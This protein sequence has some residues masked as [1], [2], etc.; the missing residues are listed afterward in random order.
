MHNTDCGYVGLRF[1]GGGAALPARLFQLASFHSTSALTVTNQFTNARPQD[2][3][4][5]DLN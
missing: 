1:L 4:F 3:S 5:F 2:F